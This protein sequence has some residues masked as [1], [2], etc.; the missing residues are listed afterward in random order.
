MEPRQGSNSPQDRTTPRVGVMAPFGSDRLD[1]IGP[2]WFRCLGEQSL[3]PSAYCFVV[4]RDGPAASDIGP[5]VPSGATL[6]LMRLSQPFHDRNARNG[7]PKDRCR[8]QHFSDLRNAARM[9]ALATDCDL[10]LSL[11][12]DVL[13][14][15]PQAIEKMVNTLL[16]PRRGNPLAPYAWDLV[17]PLTYLH[18]QGDASGC[19]NAGLWRAGAPGDPQRIWERVGVNEAVCRKPPVRIQIPMA[20]YLMRRQVLAMCKYKSHEAGE[21]MGFADALDQHEFR[22]GWMTDLKVRHV[23]GESYL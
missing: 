21:D 20:V 7:D 15:D 2:A 6:D 17:S 18:P 4:S 12:T 22:C 5:Y 16:G 3:Q 14:E 23:W 11:D 8:A 1:W 9:L 19:Y 10:F 13:L